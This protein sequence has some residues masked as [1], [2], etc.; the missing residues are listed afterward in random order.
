M[1]KIQGS[2]SFLQSSLRMNFHKEFNVV[3][4]HYKRALIEKDS[5]FLQSLIGT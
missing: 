2:G 5:Y 3:P 4:G 1:V